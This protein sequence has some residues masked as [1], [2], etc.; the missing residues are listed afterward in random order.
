MRFETLPQ[1]VSGTHWVWTDL[2]DLMGH[3]A[4]VEVDELTPEL[5]VR[6]RDALRAWTSEKRIG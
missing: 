5:I 3:G 2:D 4:P 1:R 6:I